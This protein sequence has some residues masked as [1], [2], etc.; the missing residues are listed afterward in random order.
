MKHE[1]WRCCTLWMFSD[2]WILHS[3]KTQRCST[4]NE[5]RGRRMRPW[6]L[7]QTDFA[8]SWTFFPWYCLNWAGVDVAVFLRLHTVT[9]NWQGSVCT[10]IKD[11]FDIRD[12]FHV[13]LLWL[14]ASQLP[15]VTVTVGFH[16]RAVVTL[17]S[18]TWD[19]ENPVSLLWPPFCIDFVQSVTI[20]QP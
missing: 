8:W 4:A 11:C 7:W 19:P 10:K 14:S 6:P 12:R 15:L 5:N 20:F 3:C 13:T 2:K 18:S 1:M 16:Y 17:W 9:G